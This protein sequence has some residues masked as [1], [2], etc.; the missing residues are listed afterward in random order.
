MYLENHGNTAILGGSPL[1]LPCKAAGCRQIN[2]TPTLSMTMFLLA[3]LSVA[4]VLGFGTAPYCFPNTTLN[5]MFV[6]EAGPSVDGTR[7]ERACDASDACS[8]GFRAGVHRA[9]AL[10]FCFFRGWPDVV[11]LC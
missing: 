3:G 9:S 11:L 8:V 5:L 6:G 1:L 7:A 4:E 2:A 10:V